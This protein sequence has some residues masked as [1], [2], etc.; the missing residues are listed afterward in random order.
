MKENY[1]SQWSSEMAYIFGLI[2]ADGCITKGKFKL[3]LK[4]SDEKLILDIQKILE[5]ENGIYRK[6]PHKRKDGI[7]SS[8]F[9]SLTICKKQIVSDLIKLGISTRKS[10]KDKAPT[11]IPDEYLLDFIRGYFDGDGSI[12][13]TGQGY[14]GISI[15]GGKKF[16]T[17][18]KN[19]ISE[20]NPLLNN[21]KI[22]KHSKSWVSYLDWKKKEQILCFLTLI[23]KNS[24]LFL[25]RKKSF[26]ETAI[27]TLKKELELKGIDYKKNKWRV[28]GIKGKHIGYFQTLSEAITQR[29]ITF[30][31]AA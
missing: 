18:M 19:K 23:Y 31:W 8:G 28:R 15:V 16:L 13:Q 5:C 6:L 29:N 2:W 12:F 3:G 30:G 17:F 7:N 22:Y 26:A 21:G 11:C 24:N 14:Y 27:A 1:F 10:F 4:L 20:I 25:E 9:C